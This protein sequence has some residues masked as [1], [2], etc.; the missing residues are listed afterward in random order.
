MNA[1]SNRELVKT[2]T[3]HSM[4][5]HAS[6]FIIML[7]SK[8]EVLNSSIDDVNIM[9]IINKILQYLIKRLFEVTPCP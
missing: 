1:H 4:N 3:T 5:T 6:L 7:I 2:P 9:K 8:L